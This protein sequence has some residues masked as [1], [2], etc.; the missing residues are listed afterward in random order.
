MKPQYSIVEYRWSEVKN[1]VS[2]TDW[3]LLAGGFFSAWARNEDGTVGFCV[4]IDLEMK[5]K[6]TEE[7]YKAVLLHEEGHLLYDAEALK[8]PSAGLLIDVEAEWRADR[9]AIESG[10]S[11]EDLYDANLAALEVYFKRKGLKKAM[12]K[13]ELKAA[14]ERMATYPYYQGIAH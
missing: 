12:R 7:Q 10:A 13:A 6:L 3:Q 1:T 5:E 2:E 8:T 14:K 4:F 11:A 9:H